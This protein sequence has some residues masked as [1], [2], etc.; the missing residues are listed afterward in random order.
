MR[1]VSR[2]VQLCLLALMSGIS[3]CGNKSSEVDDD[4]GLADPESA[5]LG[6]AFT[7]VDRNYTASK[8]WFNDF[9]SGDQ[10]SLSTGEGSDPWLADLDGDLYLFNRGTN[11]NFRKMSPTEGP[12]SEQ[13]ATAGAQAGDPHAALHLGEGRAL[14][15]LNIAGKL[16]VVDPK[17]G[18]TV[19]E[20]T[21]DLDTGT[22]PFHPEAFYIQGS[23]DERTIYVMHQGFGIENNTVTLNGS[24]Q[25]FVFQD[26]GGELMALDQDEATA[27]V[28]GIKVGNANP[29]AFLETSGN[30]LIVGS[31]SAMLQG[32]CSAV[33]E[34]LDLEAKSVAEIFDFTDLGFSGNGPV[35]DA[36]GGLFYA[37]LIETAT[38]TPVVV[39]V[40]PKAKTLDTVHTFPDGSFGC[41][42]TYFDESSGTLYVGD[43][44]SEGD[45]GTFSV[46]RAGAKTATE[47]KV[48]GLP[49]SAVFLGK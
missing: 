12:A 48:D 8:L 6:L 34:E 23:G 18:A 15:A 7:T 36:G 11:L 32:T 10:R 16:I 21:A 9:A 46:Y 14:L 1:S 24:S 2:S 37:N 33:V 26:K 28:Q 38:S 29:Q 39:K 22:G 49:Y 17:T 43:A 31:C 40:D 44:P 42:A 25:I 30:P 47:V 35:V 13:L 41:C 45:Q 3:G 27:K 20:I 19:Q 4:V 5:Y